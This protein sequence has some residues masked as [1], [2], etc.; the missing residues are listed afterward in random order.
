M[1]LFV[2]DG[3]AVSNRLFNSLTNNGYTTWRAVRFDWEREGGWIFRHIPS[4]GRKT[5][6]EL[7]DIMGD[8]QL[9]RRAITINEYQRALAVVKA[10]EEQTAPEP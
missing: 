3:V 7:R 6:S 2:F 10:Y 1:T 9:S 4:L 8:P 5:W